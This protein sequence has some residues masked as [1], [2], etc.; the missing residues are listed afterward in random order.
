M[1][2][3]YQCTMLVL[4]YILLLPEGQTAEAWKPSKKQCSFGNLGELSL[5]VLVSSLS[6]GL[7]PCIQFCFGIYIVPGGAL[8]PPGTKM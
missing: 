3:F 4:I 2:S 5:F 8:D 1:V 7:L 6:L